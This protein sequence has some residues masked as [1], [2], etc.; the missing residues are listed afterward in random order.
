MRRLLV[1]LLSSWSSFYDLLIDL[2]G[3]WTMEEDQMT[4]KWSNNRMWL[5]WK[6]AKQAT[7]VS[8]LVGLMGSISTLLIVGLRWQS[9]QTYSTKADCL[10]KQRAGWLV[11]EKGGKRQNKW[12]S[13]LAWL[14]ALLF[15]WLQPIAA[16]A[17]QASSKKSKSKLIGR[18]TGY[19]DWLASW[20]TFHG[21][22]LSLA[23]AAT[24]H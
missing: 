17:G 1:L 6:P 5:Q 4:T 11:G 16:W 18:L 9:T 10:K 3:R 22:C 14:V 23:L 8:W 7:V 15:G 21:K 20:L 2:F 19:A 13:W 24:S 12:Q